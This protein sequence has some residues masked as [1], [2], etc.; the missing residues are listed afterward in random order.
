MPPQPQKNDASEENR[1]TSTRQE[2]AVGF[3][4]FGRQVEPN[5]HA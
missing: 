3:Q 4:G 1:K 5:F 2:P